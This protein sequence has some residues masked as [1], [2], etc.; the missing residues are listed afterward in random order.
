MCGFVQTCVDENYYNFTLG[1]FVR[2]QRQ[3]MP[4]YRI[5]RLA[6]DGHF[7]G[8]PV[9]VECAQDQ[10]AIEKARQMVALR[11]TNRNRRD[12]HGRQYR[13]SCRSVV[14]GL[15]ARRCSCRSPSIARF[16]VGS[17][18]PKIVDALHPGR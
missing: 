10:E 3:S 11:P 1:S 13:P 15:S 2:C 7:W 5:Y 12:A 16:A 4:E 8:V 18:V 9:I 6:S 17:D 14:N